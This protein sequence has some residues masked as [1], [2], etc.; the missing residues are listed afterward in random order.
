M[1]ALAVQQFRKD[2]RR[3]ER[4][5]FGLIGLDGQCCG[6]T[7]AQCH[8]LLAVE[9]KGL[10][11]VTDLA[12][13]LELDKSTLSRTIEGLVGM[14]LVRRETN[15]GNRRSQD[16]CLT[17]EGERAAASIG[18][19]WNNYFET[20]FSGLSASKQQA[21][22]EGISLLAGSIPDVPCCVSGVT[23]IG[24]AEQSEKKTGWR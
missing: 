21:L 12:S 13:N 24:P 1:D 6:V 19:Q 4:R 8:V 5:L 7:R 23:V 11:T 2:L 16:I 15:S 17:P 18:S 3:I 10:T 20:I 14:G 9:E 22:F